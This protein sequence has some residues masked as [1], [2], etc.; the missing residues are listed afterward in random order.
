MEIIPVMTGEEHQSI[1][2]LSL[3]DVYREHGP[4]IGWRELQRRSIC[5]PTSTSEKDINTEIRHEIGHLSLT[6]DY[7]ELTH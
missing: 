1:P 3:T 5:P 4:A 6:I 7:V 2:M